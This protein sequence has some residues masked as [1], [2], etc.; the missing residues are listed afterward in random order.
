MS[1][2]AE[3]IRLIPSPL[4]GVSLAALCTAKTWDTIRKAEEARAGCRCRFADDPGPHRDGPL[5]GHERWRYEAGRATLSAIWTVCGTCHDMLHPGRVLA[6]GGMP[7]LER[8]TDLYARRCGLSRAAA[9]RR[10]SAAFDEHARSSAIP[11]WTLDLS[12]V[13]PDWPLRLKRS[14]LP[15]V[16]RHRWIGDP[17]G[18]GTPGDALG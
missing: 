15:K 1:L 3:E 12:L 14:A 7:A 10:Y 11:L 5:H 8:L 2:A 4:W 16:S 18:L 9:G 17:F 6:A 13:Q